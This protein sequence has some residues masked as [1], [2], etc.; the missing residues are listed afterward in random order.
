MQNSSCFWR[1]H[2]GLKGSA[3]ERT[4][5]SYSTAA[6]VR[7][8]RLEA[9]SGQRAVCDL[10]KPDGTDSVGDGGDEVK[11]G[12]LSDSAAAK[13]LHVINQMLALT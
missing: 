7:R 8:P 5:S 11:T 1:W 13:G 6:V 3:M 10:E 2:L 4:P 9:S 12:G